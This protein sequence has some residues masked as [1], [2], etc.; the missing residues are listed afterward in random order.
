MLCRSSRS[1]MVLVL[2]GG[3][4]AVA[5]AVRAVPAQTVSFE[6]G[7][8][9]P[10]GN[11][12]YDYAFVDANIGFAVGGGGSVLATTDAG[13]SWDLRSDVSTFHPDLYAVH[14]F[15]P[16]HLLAIGEGPGVF[17]SL[18]GGATWIAVSNPSTGRLR[19]LAVAGDGRLDA[20]GENGELI[21]STDDGAS[22]TEIGPGVG[23]IEGQWWVDANTGYAVGFQ[24]AHRTTDGGMNWTQAFPL[25]PFGY[26]E[27][28][29]VN[30][31]DGLAIADFA[32]VETTD[33]GAT[34]TRVDQFV[35]PLYRFRTLYLSPT[36]WLTI[37][38]LEGAEL[39]ESFDAGES[40]T[41][42]TETLAIGF[43]ALE[44]TPS[45]RIVMASSLG[46][47]FFSDDDGHTLTNAAANLDENAP[48]SILSI[49]ARPDG[50]LFA[51]N[52][53]TTAA[54]PETWLR[55]DDGGHTWTRPAQSPGIRWVSNICFPNDGVGLAGGGTSLS[56][57]TDGGATWT[58]GS[59]PDGASVGDLDH[60]LGWTFLGTWASTGTSGVYRSSDHGVTWSATGG[61]PSTF[62]VAR[63]QM[64]TASQGYVF[65]SLNT[66]PRLYK[67][68]NQGGSWNQ[69]TPIDLAGVD[70]LY[71]F[72]LQTAVAIRGVSDPALL[73]TSDG[74]AT[75]SVLPTAQTLREFACSPG[76][77]CLA[78]RGYFGLERPF[79]TTDAGQTWSELET[80]AQFRLTAAH[81]GSERIVVGGDGTRLLGGQ[82]ESSTSVNPPA[83]DPF[84]AEGTRQVEAI[85]DLRIAPLPAV[86]HS[87]VAFR[88]RVAGRVEVEIFDVAARRVRLLI[89]GHLRAGDHSVTWDGLDDAGDPVPSGAFLVRVR[90]G[91]DTQRG[92]LVYLR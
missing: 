42:L 20:A 68:T 41:S 2:A 26:H 38:N 92:R 52:L 56:R 8:P 10:Q 40:W 13:S 21:R 50:V 64:V 22:W 35:P 1:R 91:A 17:R 71:W 79:F 48:A 37:T 34:W 6:W 3:C 45:G 55:S 14:A 73:R 61:L 77:V 39:W 24:V 60:E 49:G 76:G 16:W 74:G 63:V 62:D 32:R 59:T 31:D 75:W 19:H 51:S 36:H 83:D 15:D 82:L 53:P 70:D 47:L 65:G 29:F 44:E 30:A 69:V 88:L 4:L 86:S 23:D 81:V 89:S 54:L 58:L 28:S 87:R 57:T 84:E 27:I 85:S 11:P 72:D 66:T 78:L 5:A 90:A 7:H 12:I 9:Q 25:D 46:D 18:D 80:P 67:T 43:L 33:G